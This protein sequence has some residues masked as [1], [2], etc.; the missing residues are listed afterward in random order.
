MVERRCK[1]YDQA[2]FS[3][4]E[5]ELVESENTMNQSDILNNKESDSSH[6]ILF[7]CPAFRKIQRNKDFSKDKDLCDFMRQVIQHCM[8]NDE[9]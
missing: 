5:Q 7:E 3:T 2:M 8:E 6:H 9:D 4:H 1:E